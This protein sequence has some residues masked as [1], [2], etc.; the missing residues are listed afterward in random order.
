MKGRW[1]P[2]S[3]PRRWDLGSEAPSYFFFFPF[4]DYLLVGSCGGSCLLSV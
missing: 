3:E 2:C 1:D 4:P